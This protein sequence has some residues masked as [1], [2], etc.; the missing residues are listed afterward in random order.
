MLIAFSV[1]ADI[2]HVR[3][4]IMRDRGGSPPH[5]QPPQSAVS[6]QAERKG[7]MGKPLAL[8]EAQSLIADIL[9]YVSR[10]D[11]GTRSLGTDDIERDLGESSGLSKRLVTLLTDGGYLTTTPIS[12]WESRDEHVDIRITAAGV[13]ALQ[14]TTKSRRVATE[15]R[16]R[17]VLAVA[18]DVV[19]LAGAA[20][21]TWRATFG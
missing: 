8:H 12:N 17:D 14:R 18:A 6:H 16:A 5:P 1:V 2:F 9:D 11:R 10:R 4:V 7:T 13:A 19:T 3:R 20:Y 21:A 15:M